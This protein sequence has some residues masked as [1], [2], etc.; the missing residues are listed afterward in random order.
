MSNKSTAGMRA[1]DNT[2]HKSTLD[3]V[4]LAMK[5][6]REAKKNSSDPMPDEIWFN[7]LYPS[8]DLV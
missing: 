8:G 7:I 5:C 3:D 4:S 6:W 2:E 1:N